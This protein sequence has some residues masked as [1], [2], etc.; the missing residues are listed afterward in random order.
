MNKTLE[1]S[2]KFYFMF[3]E[4]IFTIVHDKVEQKS[5]YSNFLSEKN[6]G[7]NII[8]VCLDRDENVK[9]LTL[10]NGEMVN[11]FNSV[12]DVIASIDAVGVE[13]VERFNGVLHPVVYSFKELM[14]KFEKMKTNN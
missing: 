6:N 8:G 12:I 3:D 13:Y 2:K 11:V 10:S 4:K 7:L 9:T 14:T 5:C 1:N